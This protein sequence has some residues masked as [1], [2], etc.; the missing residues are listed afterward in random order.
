MPLRDRNGEIVAAARVIMQTFPGQTEQN[1]L[2][3][4]LPVMKDLEARIQLLHDPLQ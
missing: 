2:A 1:A 3:R 4:A